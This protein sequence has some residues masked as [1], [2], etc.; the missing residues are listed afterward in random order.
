MSPQQI[1]GQDFGKSDQQ[2]SFFPDLIQALNNLTSSC[3]QTLKYWHPTTCTCVQRFQQR[4]SCS[5]IATSKPYKSMCSTKV[6][7]APSSK[8]VLAHELIGNY[9]HRHR[10]MHKILKKQTKKTPLHSNIPPDHC[11]L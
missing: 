1:C 2:F 4:F 8:S 6:H 5:H 10:S 7:L 3:L 9:S 11:I